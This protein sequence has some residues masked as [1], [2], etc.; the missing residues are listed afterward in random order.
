MLTPT[1]PDGD[2]P[3]HGQPAD[4]ALV[5][6]GARGTRDDLYLIRYSVFFL[7]SLLSYRAQTLLRAE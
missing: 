5:Y 1:L 3:C 2:P 6:R 7:N 4:R